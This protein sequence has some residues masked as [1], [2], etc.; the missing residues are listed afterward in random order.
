ME[1]IFRAIF[2]SLWNLILITDTTINSGLF[3]N[4]EMAGHNIS[5]AKNYIWGIFEEVFPQFTDLDVQKANE[6]IQVRK[7]YSQAKKIP[8][9]YAN[10]KNTEIR[11]MKKAPFSILLTEDTGTLTFHKDGNMDITEVMV[12]E[13]E[14]ARERFTREAQAASALNH[15][16][17]TT[18]FDLLDSDDQHFT[19]M[20]YV[21]GKTL[22][23][24]EELPPTTIID[25]IGKEL[26]M[27]RPRCASLGLDTA[28]LA[29]QM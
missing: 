23:E 2:W 26:A 12:A 8:D 18:V 14:E 29:V 21:E 20:E 5:N 3:K 6:G 11:V 22:R 1:S 16:N 24:I 17:I 10:A 9:K 19:C 28:K 13:S 15:P 25:I 4:L 7:I 27:T